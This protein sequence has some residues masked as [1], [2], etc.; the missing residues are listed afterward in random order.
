MGSSFG[1]VGEKMAQR[2]AKETRSPGGDKIDWKK[3]LRK[4]EGKKKKNF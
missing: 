4:D 3:K 2:V 1:E